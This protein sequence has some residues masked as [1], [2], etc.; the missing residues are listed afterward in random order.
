VVI[1][2]AGPRLAEAA[3]KIAELSGLGSS[4]VGTTFVALSTSLPEL[5]ASITAVRMGAF[6]LIIGNIF[7]SNA[8]NM[9]L[10]VPLDA[11]YPGSLFAA[12]NPSHVISVLA[13]IV[14]TAVVILGQ[15]YGPDRRRRFLEPDAWLVILLVCGA[16]GLV[17]AMA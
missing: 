14:C 6:D 2:V 3:G 15:L 7:G 10:F 5:V 4:F 9:V 8:F 16:I 1:C 12:A 13:V 17:Y 11:A